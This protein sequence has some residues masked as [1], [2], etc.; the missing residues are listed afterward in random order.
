[1]PY[2]IIDALQEKELFIFDMDGTIY[3][4]GKVFEGANDTLCRLT[5][6][7][8]KVVFLTNNSSRSVQDYRLKLSKMGFDVKADIITSGIVAIDFLKNNY[9]NKKI[10][11]FGTNS[12]KQEFLS[13]GIEL[14]QNDAD[15][16]VL[17]FH[18]ELTYQDLDKLCAYAREGK[19]YIA[20]HPDINCPTEDGF[21]PDVGAM[22]ELIY[23]ST[24]RRPDYICGKPSNILAQFIQRAYNTSP[25]KIVMV[26][27][28]LVTDIKTAKNFGYT[29]LLVLSGET[30]QKMLS[31]SDIVPDL[32]LP[33]INYIFNL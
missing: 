21:M 15:V 25:D 32:I 9:S 16:A 3:L 2:K 11:L 22:I 30:D 20:T 10:Y 28:R 31:Q 13:R 18:T 4:G 24:K 17:G 26:G 23:A 12:L 8:K 27:D 5:A 7:G 1:M 6:S 29:G 14:V 33:N 19:P